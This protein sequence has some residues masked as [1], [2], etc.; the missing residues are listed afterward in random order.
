MQALIRDGTPVYMSLQ[1]HKKIRRNSADFFAYIQV[2]LEFI[3]NLCTKNVCAQI[4]VF[5]FVGIWF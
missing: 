5:H 3:L 1:H 4:R 2:I